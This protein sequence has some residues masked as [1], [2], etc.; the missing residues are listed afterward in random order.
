METIKGQWS[1]PRNE[2]IN[3]VGEDID[4]ITKAVMT[5]MQQEDGRPV[6][7]RCK[8]KMSSRG[9]TWMCNICGKTQVKEYKTNIVHRGKAHNTRNPAC[10]YCGGITKKS[11]PPGKHAGYK[12][13]NCKKQMVKTKVEKIIKSKE[14][15][16]TLV[17]WKEFKEFRCQNPLK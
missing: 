13:F 15:T 16:V 9:L 2:V 5:D 6:C 8:K 12:C 3:I 11:G 7:P 14:N 1:K 17:F 4:K 10:V